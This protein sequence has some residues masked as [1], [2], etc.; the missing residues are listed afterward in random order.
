M[1]KTRWLPKIFN[2][3]LA[4]NKI[5]K[6]LDVSKLLKEMLHFWFPFYAEFILLKCFAKFN[7]LE[8]RNQTKTST[9]RKFCKNY[10]L[11]C[12]Y[13]TTSNLSSFL[14]YSLFQV[15][16]MKSWAVFHCSEMRMLC[17]IQTLH[18]VTW[19]VFMV[20][21]S[22]RCFGLLFFTLAGLPLLACFLQVWWQYFNSVFHLHI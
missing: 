9:D 6:I 15:R 1:T 20:Y 21:E 3:E 2:G 16:H 22:L 11:L 17:L 4:L 13:T 12:T 18:R 8:K 10:V 19:V 14:F 7:E 5:Q